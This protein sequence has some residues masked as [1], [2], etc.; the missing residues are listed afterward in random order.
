MSL[1][2]GATVITFIHTR[3]PARA[4]A[5]YTET[6]GF[7]LVAEDPYASVIDL[8]GVT[9]RIVEIKDHAPNPHT[10]LG[11]DVQDIDADL[12]ALNAKGVKAEIYEGFGQDAHG[13]WTA[14]DGRAKIAWFLDPDGNNLSLTQRG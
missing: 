1:G 10:V 9:L 14:P 3:D 2:P 8:N 13:I 7:K 11:W 5:F 4:K 6:L 12:R